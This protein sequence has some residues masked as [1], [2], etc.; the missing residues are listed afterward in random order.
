MSD[1]YTN[2]PESYDYDPEEE[3][4]EEVREWLKEWSHKLSGESKEI[5]EKVLETYDIL[6]RGE[7]EDLPLE[8]EN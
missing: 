8:E 3:A 6:H 5:M 2:D 4:Y 1:Y 7:S